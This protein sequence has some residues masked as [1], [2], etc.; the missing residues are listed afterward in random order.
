[1]KE[2]IL[3]VIFSMSFTKHLFGKEFTPKFQNMDHQFTGRQN[4]RSILWEKKKKSQASF[5]WSIVV[6]KEAKRPK[7]PEEKILSF[8]VD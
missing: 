1:M 6:K 5:I 3:P 8:I 7:N 4:K 2:D